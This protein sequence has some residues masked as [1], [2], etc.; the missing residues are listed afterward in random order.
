[1]RNPANFTSNDTRLFYATAF[2]RS[3]AAGLTGVAAAIAL[4][5]RALSVRQTGYVI[6]AGLGGMAVATAF[7]TLM[8]DRL[9]R[10]RTLAVLA[11]LSACG[12]AALAAVEAF[13]ILVVLAF[14][15]MVNAMGRD[16]GAAAAIDQSA[17]AD[18]ATPERRTWTFAW[19]NVV[20]D[21]GQTLGSAAGALPVLIATAWGV[22]RATGHAWTFVGCAV[23]LAASAVAY[24]ALSPHVE[25]AGARRPPLAQIDRHT[26]AIAS[27]LVLLFGLDSLGSGF[28]NS[29]L[30]AYWFFE[31]YG[32]SELHVAALFAAARL[33]NAAS[34]ILAAW[35]ARRIGLVNTM[36]LTHLPSSVFLML[37]PLAPGAAG[38]AALFLARE[39]LVEMDVPARQS[40]MMAI[41]APEQR[42]FVSGVTNVTR[43]AGW[44]VGP[45]IAGALMQAVGSA[46][47]LFIGGGLKICYDVL[48]YSQFHRVRA[49]EESVTRR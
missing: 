45:M 39:A 12:Y 2:V 15:G 38:A 48:L 18:V 20:L 14:V 46:T 25:T 16:R 9:G 37:A 5:E 7:V 36:V 13:R 43:L 33:L 32:L 8:A 17:L 4:G 47:P 44:A 31:R 22:S 34:H 29:A 21:A 23:A 24:T 10:R 26:R 1:V 49:P 35:L 40:Y 6:G 30:I 42:T 41:V 19:Y 11:L 27:K 28:L 3:T